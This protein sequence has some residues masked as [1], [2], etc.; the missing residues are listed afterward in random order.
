MDKE[1]E[2]AIKLNKKIYL[3]IKKGLDFQDFRNVADE[4]IE[5]NSLEELCRLLSKLK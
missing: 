5:W 3:A 1:K 2:E 4:I